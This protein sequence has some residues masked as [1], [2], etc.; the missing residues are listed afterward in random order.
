MKKLLV[1]CV[2]L[3]LLLG[4][5]ATAS[6]AE[7]KAV[8]DATLASMG[9]GSMKAMTDQEGMAVRGK[10][11]LSFGLGFAFRPGAAASINGFAN[12]FPKFGGGGNFSIASFNGVA[13]GGGFAIAGGF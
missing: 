9:L 1:I 8:S 12:L 13:I 3:G 2:A 5:T 11:T 7:P 4:L 6:A 10:A